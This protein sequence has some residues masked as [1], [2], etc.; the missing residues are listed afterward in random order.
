VI[1]TAYFDE[2]D[3]HGPA[4]TVIMTCFWGHTYQ[5]QRFETKLRRLQAKYGFKIFHA[6]DF[7][8][9]VGEFDGW[10]DGKCYDLT[11]ELNK[12]AFGSL[13]EG[14]SIAVNREKYEK[15]YRAVI[16]KKLPVDS[17]LGIC[18]R[19]LLIWVTG[20][21]MR[22]GKRPKLHVVVEDGH[23]NVNDTV[24]IFQELK[25]RYERRR[26]Y[27]L[28]DITISDK[29]S[30]D[31]LMIA[32]FLGAAHSMMREQS[33]G[34]VTPEPGRNICALSH[35]RGANVIGL[36]PD[37]YEQFIDQAIAARSERNQARLERKTRTKRSAR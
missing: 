28:E 5:W 15:E 6:K 7:K 27:V 10:S 36:A 30:A 14:V 20:Q 25:M 23:V 3:T 34:I 17:Q 31:P 13:A 35:R 4:P 12:A 32:D 37:G 1:F 8:A 24:R 9:R 19:S 21:V 18:F 22:I 11:V 29:K 2:S 16:D 26:I 33:I